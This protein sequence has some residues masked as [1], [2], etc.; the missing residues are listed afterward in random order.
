MLS[1]PEVVEYIFLHEEGVL[2]AMK[3]NAI[4]VDCT[5]VNPSFS[6]K[7]KSVAQKVGVRF[8]DAPVAGTKPHAENAELVFFAG[9]EKSLLGEVEP[10]L[11]FMGKKVLNIGDTG[12]G[13]SLKC[14]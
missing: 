7:S 11:Q 12:K 3:E 14:W 13:A 5:T 8:M 6:L 10:Y 2:S 1:K 9:A 4:W